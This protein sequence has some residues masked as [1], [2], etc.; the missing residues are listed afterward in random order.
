[1]VC[2]LKVLAP[3]ADCSYGE[4]TD[5]GK[6]SQSRE[7]HDEGEGDVDSSNRIHSNPMA[8]KDAVHYSE[9]EDT[10]HAEYRGNCVAYELYGLGFHACADILSL[11]TNFVKSLN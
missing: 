7:E 6:H 2:P 1:M 9:E 8:N 5:G 11:L 4:G 3:Y 10:H